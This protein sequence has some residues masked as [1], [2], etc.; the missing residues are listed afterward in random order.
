[1]YTCFDFFS[2]CPGQIGTTIPCM[3]LPPT[4]YIH[5][6]TCLSSSRT[7]SPCSL[8]DAFSH[9]IVHCFRVPS[10]HAFPHRNGSLYLEKS[11]ASCTKLTLTHYIIQQLTVTSFFFFFFPFSPFSPPSVLSNT[12]TKKPLY[13]NTSAK[14]SRVSSSKINISII[15]LVSHIYS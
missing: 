7:L 11:V 6:S 9:C 2:P 1:V 12:Q 15:I 14:G 4:T 3:T 10:A 13:Q 8:L 5:P